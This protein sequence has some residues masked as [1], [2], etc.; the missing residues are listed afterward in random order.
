MKSTEES[1]KPN[2]RACASC[3]LDEMDFVCGHPDAGVFGKFVRVAAGEGGHCGPLLPKFEQHPLRKPN[4][5]L[6]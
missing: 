2:C 1:A 4:G 5:D 6:G 3:Y